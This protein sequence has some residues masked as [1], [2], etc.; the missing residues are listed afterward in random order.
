MGLKMREKIISVSFKPK[1]EILLCHL[2]DTRDLECK[3]LALYEELLFR[4][5]ILILPLSYDLS[6]VSAEFVH[7]WAVLVLTLTIPQEKFA[8]FRAAKRGPDKSTVSHE[9][10]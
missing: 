5:L 1:L 8:I 10:I 7:I 6:C 9:L 4:C 2:A 3:F